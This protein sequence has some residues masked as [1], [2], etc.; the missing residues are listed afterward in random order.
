[1][2]LEQKVCLITGAG[3]GIGRAG[4]LLFA[5]EGATIVVVDIAKEKGEQTVDMIKAAGGE[6]MFI[7]VD[8]SK[9]AQVEAMVKSALDSY[10]RIDILY[11]NAGI[12]LSGDILIDELSE[13]T[14]DRI[15]GVNLKGHYLCCKYAIPEIAKAG[16]GSIINT[17]STAALSASEMGAYAASKGGVVSLTR[18]LAVQ[19][20]RKKIRANVICPGPIRTPLLTERRAIAQNQQFVPTGPLLE[21]VGQPEEVAHLALFLACDESSYV[22]GAVFVVD[23]GLTAR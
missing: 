13:E 10:H 8:V 15:V 20:A 2:R 19:Y 17:A 21:R 18:S 6:A 12:G 16:G 11:N 22:T 14:W 7:Q 3:S 4:A 9:A 5:Q 23:G 1:M